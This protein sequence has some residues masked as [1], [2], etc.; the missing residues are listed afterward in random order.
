MFK[1]TNYSSFILWLEIKNSR[2]KNTFL[3]LTKNHSFFSQGLGL[4]ICLDLGKVNT[5]QCGTQL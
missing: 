1:N 2:L 4:K 3:K 5:A